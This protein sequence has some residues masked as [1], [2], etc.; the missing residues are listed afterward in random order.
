[1]TVFVNLSCV[2]DSDVSRGFLYRLGRWSARHAVAVILIWVSLVVGAVIGNRALGGVYAD[3]F[4]L[5]GTSAQQ[6]ADLLQAHR[7]SA[8]GQ[9]GLIVFAVS[10][11]SLTSQRSAIEQSMTAVRELPDVLG[12]SDP[13]APT[14]IAKSGQIAY[15][16]AHFSVNPQTLGPR[17]LATVNRAVAPARAAGVSVN[18]GGQLGQAAKLKNRD[19]RSEEI[20][21]IAAFIVLL[22]GFGSVY[23]AGLPILSAL[24]GAF[25][26]LSVLGMLAAASTFPTVSPTLA[27]MMGLGVGIDYA[28]FL[29]TRHRQLVMDGVEPADAAA[30]SLAASG[31]AVLVAA[32]T[33]IIALLGLY[34]SGLSFIG[35]LG[36]AA[37]ITVAVAALGALTVVPA[38]LALMGRRIDRLQVRRP[39]AEASGEHAGWQ[40]YAERVG[41]RPWAYLLAGVA[42]LGILAIPAFSL[43]LGHIDAGA[44]PAGSTAKIAYDELSTGFGPGANGPFTVVAKL[45]PGVP[46]TERASLQKLLYADL[47]KTPDV[48]MV[49]PVK[50]TP[51]GAL[52]YATVLPRTDPQS[53]ATDQLMRALQTDTLPSALYFTGSTGYVTGSLAGQLQFRDEID[54][55]M[56]LIIATVIAAAFVVLLFAF[57]SPVLALKAGILNL[58]SI[59]AAYGVVVAVF[60]WGWGSSL[61]GVSEKVPIES[62]VPMMIFAIVFGL[63]MDYE[64]FLLSRVREAWLRT[65][66]NHQSV[67]HGLATTARVITCAA[68][69]MT[70]VFI[71]FLLSTNV[72][73]KMLALGLG[74]SVLIDASVIR[75][76][77]VPATMFLLGRYNWWTPR[78]LR[79][80]VSA[81][82]GTKKN[83]LPVP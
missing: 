25:A 24:A 50:A 82:P 21:I 4:A 29:A 76:V 60:Q 62:Y 69:I 36:L 16:S 45:G 42:L 51:D 52:L 70:S 1:M 49:S 53:P 43:Q 8:G 30:R 38:L 73:V 71:A 83:A 27:I 47:V 28:L 72:I 37:C 63:S 18:Y 40:R 3:N 5:P 67:A 74:L 35:K 9:G 81:R 7:P 17:Y 26:G 55:R 61:F 41:A 65:G 75:L 32:L 44:D 46:G 54:S 80:P 78:W 20:G 68:L 57:R 48:A 19:P 58:F 10:S 22:I 56:P 64:V 33:V 14:A 31:R 2:T 12:A 59:G 34:A 6:A 77:V 66:D 23:A 13:L 15:S 39:V 11:G 79:G